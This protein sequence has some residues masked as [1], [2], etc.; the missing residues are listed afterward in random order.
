MPPP[1]TK[2][3]A[4]ILLA[5]TAFMLAACGG[6]TPQTTAEPKRIWHD[7][8][9]APLPL[10]RY[11][12]VATADDAGGVIVLGKRLDTDELV[13]LRWSDAT[14]WQS[15][16]VEASGLTGVQT[17]TSRGRI[18]LFGSDSTRWY[19]TDFDAAATRRMQPICDGELDAS[20]QPSAP[21]KYRFGR[22]STGEIVAWVE[23]VDTSTQRTLIRTRAISGGNCGPV[24]EF[25]VADNGYVTA[26]ALVRD[27]SGDLVKLATALPGSETWIA[28]RST[29]PAAAGEYVRVSSVFCPFGRCGSETNRSANGP[30]IE[31]N[32]VA[33]VLITSYG[34]SPV[35]SG[36]SRLVNG[37][38]QPFFPLDSLPGAPHVGSGTRFVNTDGTAYW[39][40]SVDG[41]YKV[42]ATQGDSPI[43]TA[44]PSTSCG[45]E[46]VRFSSDTSNEFALLTQD[47]TLN[48]YRFQV[49]VRNGT[50]Y[51]LQQD[52]LLAASIVLA[53][54]SDIQS[55]TD[56]RALADGRGT[57]VGVST[58]AVD[59]SARPQARVWVMS[60]Y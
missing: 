58:P 54:E 36:W 6:G 5:A 15:P 10:N 57:V 39:L 24:Q 8:T 38:L 43:A 7:L 4:R 9:A 33:S 29:A 52:S 49:H 13:S 45:N 26:L 46:C 53:S 18:V 17:V 19:R 55:L 28:A 30:K 14:G 50:A 60:R 37:M 12:V 22:D 34:A 21:Y 23:R 25:P 59:T 1:S 40:T 51:T 2:T 44:A 56:F 11:S 16:V 3:R 47:A 42:L 27:A 20:A 31:N 48:G 35:E 41:K 32:G